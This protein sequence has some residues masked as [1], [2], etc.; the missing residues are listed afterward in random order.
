MNN[1]KRLVVVIGLG[2]TIAM[3]TQSASGGAIPS[4]TAEAIVGA[5]P[6]LA[7]RYRIHAYNFRNV[8]SVELGLNDMVSLVYEIRKWETE[9][10]VGVVIS[11]GTDT[12][13]ETSWCLDLLLQTDMPVIF[14]GAMR[15][16][17]QSG[18][19]GPANILAAIETAASPKARGK[20]VL[21]VFNDE[22]HAARFVTKT[23]TSS[24]AAFQSPNGGPIGFVTENQP[25]FLFDLE[26]VSVVQLRTPP[27]PTA[28]ALLST[29]MGDDGRAITAI[30][31][32]GFDG[33]VIE[34]AGGG[35]TS[36]SVAVVLKHVA[37]KIP[38]ILASKVGSGRILS[39]SYGFP[40]SERD[41]LAH[42][43]ISAGWLSG[44]KARVL[45]LC[46]L[47][48]GLSGAEFS[49]AFSSRVLGG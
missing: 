13:E 46:L 35:H 43:L 29:G 15:T 16:P 7:G 19:D 26:K 25:A 12:I 24:V 8:P 18:A 40:G 33:L 32:C 49:D 39:N 11:Q 20:G 4:L 31:D 23:N 14:T 30:A 3:A 1:E 28:V 36:S 10:A 44:T 38:V 5:V 48:S 37:K 27:D 6:E 45:M 22:I 47:A 17:T 9:G 41:L 34:A 21:V 2:G 42:G